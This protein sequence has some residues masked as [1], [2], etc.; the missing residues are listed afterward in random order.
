MTN[1]ISNEVSQIALQFIQARHMSKIVTGCL[2]VENVPVIL[3]IAKARTSQLVTDSRNVG[4]ITSI[5]RKRFVRF[6]KAA[7]SG[8]RTRVCGSRTR[9]LT[10]PRKTKCGRVL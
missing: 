9:H 3:Q 10:L 6:V 8:C 4:R 5:V 2:F 7:G 1:F